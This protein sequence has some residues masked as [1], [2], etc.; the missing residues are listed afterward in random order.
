MAT[1][2]EGTDS[3]EIYIESD[4]G[5]ASEH[6]MPFGIKAWYNNPAS[7]DNAQVEF[8]IQ[9]SMPNCDKIKNVPCKPKFVTENRLETT[10]FFVDSCYQYCSKDSPGDQL[11]KPA[12]L[13]CNDMND[14]NWRLDGYAWKRDFNCFWKGF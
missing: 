13:D 2:H 14:A 3:I 5:R 11:L 1:P 6:T 12:D 10:P 9:K 7:L 4:K 8:E